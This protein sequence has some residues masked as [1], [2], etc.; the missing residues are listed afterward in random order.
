MR[1]QACNLRKFFLN[2]VAA[3]CLA[4]ASGTALAGEN[5]RAYQIPAQS[6]GRALH[7]FGLQSGMTRHRQ[8]E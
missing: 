7:D 5:N 8:R 2:G 1:L 6:L 4:L 3:S